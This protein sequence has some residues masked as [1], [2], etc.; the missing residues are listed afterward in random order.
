M[1]R[2]KETILRLH[3]T[4]AHPQ[5]E[6]CIREMECTDCLLCVRRVQWR[7]LGHREMKAVN[8]SD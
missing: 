1:R 4:I 5:L 8:V 2:D 6:Y 7:A 3:K